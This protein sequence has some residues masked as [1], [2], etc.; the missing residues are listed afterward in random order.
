MKILAIDQQKVIIEASVE[1]AKM[2]TEGPIK[3]G[4]TV[5][6]SKLYS[7]LISVG[8]SS[9]DAKNI[10]EE[11]RCMASNLEFLIPLMKRGNEEPVLV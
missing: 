11:L 7:N 3:T 4:E 5:Q 6:L 8:T 1:E 9:S 10:A 2:L